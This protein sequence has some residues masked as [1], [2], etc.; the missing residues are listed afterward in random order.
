MYYTSIFFAGDFFFFLLLTPSWRNDPIGLA[1][2]FRTGGSN[3]DQC[4]A[5]VLANGKCRSS[6][7]SA[8]GCLTPGDCLTVQIVSLNLDSQ[9]GWMMMM[10][11]MM[12]P[13]FC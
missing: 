11:T 7:G 2:F 6:T 5:Q 12:M 1:Q 10:M 13:F 9:K 4:S 8:L 3:T